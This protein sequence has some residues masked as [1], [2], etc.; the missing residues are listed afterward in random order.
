[1]GR[2]RFDRLALALCLGAS[3]DASAA[4]TTAIK[5]DHFGYRP[6]DAKVAI[7]T[8][9]PGPTVQVRSSDGTVIF[10]V[11]TNG[12][13][14]TSRGLDSASGDQVWWV[15]F[16]PF[17]SG[18]TYHLYSPLLA[19]ESYTFDVRDDVYNDVVRAAVKSFYYQRCGVAKPAAFAGPWADALACHGADAI[20][21]P[22]AGH[23]NHGPKDLRGGW[24][25]A[26]D[27]NKYMW[28]AT[29]LAVLFLLKAYE[30]NPGF[31]LD[32]DL[33]IPESG[34]GVPDL[35]DEVKWE[36][37]WVLKMQLPDGSV[38]GRMQAAG[39]TTASPPSAD[40]TVRYY[41]DPTLESG[42]MLAG[43]SAV[44]SRA[45]QGA[46]QAA[47]AAT[48]KAA[49]Q[50]SWNWL[51][52]QGDSPEKAWA[53]AEVFRMDPTVSSAGSYVA[54]FQPSSWSGVF[55]NV[56]AFDTQAALAYIQTPGASAAVVNN[57]RASV[58][59]QVDY[60]FD[61]DDQYRNGMP[62]WSYYWGSNAIRAGYG[63]FL[64]TAARLG[65]TGAHTAAQCRAHALEFL[66]F[67]HGQNAMS[68][69]YLTNMSGLGGEHSSWQF[70]HSWFG[71]SDS[72]YSR[73][74]HIGKPPGMAEPF[75]PYFAGVDNHGINDNKTSTLG[76]A[77]GFLVGGPNASYGGDASPPLGAVYAN[78][79]YRDWNDQT[80]WTA[81][82]WEITENSIG[83]QGP[84]VALG[85]YF[86]RPPPPSGPT[87]FYTVNPCRLVDTRHPGQGAPSLGAGQNR[88]FTLAGACGVPSDARAVVAN[89]AVTSPSSAGHL[90]FYPAGAP[91][92]TISTISYSAGQTRANNAVLLLGGAGAVAVHCGQATG[93][94]ELIVDV[95]GY[96]R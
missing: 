86:M 71:L 26:G 74:Q 76:P 88:T 37:N 18:G 31:F 80:V 38:L 93:T 28:G 40:V 73:A 16:S 62:G 22:A 84:Y 49:A 56:V 70:Y 92:P 35:L 8:T 65:L 42:A 67:F 3:E 79:F 82:T 46:G 24:H 20:T 61:S 54:G 12:G 87:S 96:F 83:Y 66:R 58:S 69:V 90:R 19:A 68:M 75:Y 4:V 10:T 95:F 45:F 78:R 53:A 81:R 1:M 52:T 41:Q 11:P 60:I 94:V 91:L 9:N 77:P 39:F 25:D 13:S 5:L 33:N 36:L 27:Y 85:A 50:A 51:L 17:T 59:S 89:I 2:V 64:M 43:V 6:A 29:G 14:V 44:A 55:F 30:D 34:N 48:L 63:V 7:F 72:A 57:M 23:V 32:G 15:D 21:G 47:Y